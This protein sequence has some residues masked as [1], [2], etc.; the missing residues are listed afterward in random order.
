MDKWA[1]KYKETMSFT[2]GIRQYDTNPSNQL[3]DAL[4]FL[5]TKLVEVI[6]DQGEICVRYRDSICKQYVDEYGYE[7]EFDGYKTF[8]VGLNMYGI[9]TF[10]DKV[11]KYDICATFEYNGI[12]WSIGLY[13]KK[14]D[15]SELALKHGG[16]GHVG[17]AGFV[18]SELP[19]KK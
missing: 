7:C 15:V 1:W 18:S 12:D 17:A 2:E 6:C 11:D 19:F 14:V 8:A 5:D 3:W 9:L 10:G 4:L 16:G 13:S